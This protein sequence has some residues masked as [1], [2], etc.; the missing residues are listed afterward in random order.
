MKQATVPMAVL[1]FTFKGKINL[2]LYMNGT[3]N[4][5]L[6]RMSLNLAE[7]H[8]NHVVCNQ[9]KPVLTKANEH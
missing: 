6:V 2:V 1:A 4:D 5:M 9:L 8:V 7:K 3:L